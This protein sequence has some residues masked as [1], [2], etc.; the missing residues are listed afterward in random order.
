M[1]SDGLSEM[2]GHK[3]LTDLAAASV[4]LADKARQLIDAANAAG[5]RDNISVV[6]VQAAADSP[7]RGFMSRL[8]GAA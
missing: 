6:L 2:V 3:E 7:K 5:G 4:P 8:L 1:C